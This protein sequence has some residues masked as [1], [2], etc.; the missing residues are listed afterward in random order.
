MRLSPKT[1]ILLL[2]EALVCIPYSINLLRNMNLAN[3][4]S[5]SLYGIFRGLHKE[6]QKRY[7][8]DMMLFLAELDISQS[9]SVSDAM[10][11]VASIADD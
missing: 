3:G 4:T 11:Y 2:L 5:C 10:N 7:A 6:E 8:G 1:R 9:E